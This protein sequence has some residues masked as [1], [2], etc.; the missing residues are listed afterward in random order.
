MQGLCFCFNGFCAWIVIV[1]AIVTN[2]S[3]IDHPANPFIMH[4]YKVLPSKDTSHYR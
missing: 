3:K 1:I 2:R 4:V